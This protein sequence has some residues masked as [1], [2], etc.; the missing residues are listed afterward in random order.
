VLLSSIG[1]PSPSYTSALISSIIV[2]RRFIRQNREIARVNSTQSLRIRNLEAEISRL[3]AENIAIREQAINSAQEVERLRSSQR[4]FRDVSR[5]KEQLGAKLSEAGA[6]VTELGALPEKAKRRSSQHQRRR[7]GLVEPV[8]SPDQKDWKNRQTIGGG[9][10]GERQSQDGRLPV[11]VEGKHYPRKTLESLEISRLLDDDAA[12]SESP[13]LGP[14]PVAHFEVAEPIDFAPAPTPASSVAQ[15]L[16]RYQD[17]EIDVKAL[18]GNFERRRRRRASALLEDMPTLS[19][20]TT[21]ASNATEQRM[22]LKSGAKRKLDV[23][24]DACTTEFAPSELNDF[25]FQRKAVASETPQARPKGSRFIKSVTASIA[26]NAATKDCSTK[27]EPAA[28]KVLAPRSTN[29]P[30]KSKRTGLKEKMVPTK[31]EMGS[32]A[33]AQEQV[34]HKRTKATGADSTTHIHPP[35]VDHVVIPQEHASTKLPP[36]TPAGLDLFSPVSTE[37][38]AKTG[39]QTE[40]ALTASVEDVLGGVDGRTSRRARGAVSYTEPSLRAKM[41]RPTKG[42]VPAVG[43][44]TNGFKAQQIETN[45]RA[46]IQD[47]QFSQD[48]S[49]VKMRT[50]TI[51][52]EKPTDESFA[53]KGVP[54]AKDEPTSPLIN[55]VGKS[56]SREAPSGEGQEA[57]NSPDV[58]ADAQQ[59]EGAFESLSIFDGPVSSPHDSPNTATVQSRNPSRRHSSNPARLQRVGQE[60]QKPFVSSDRPQSKNSAAGTDD[61]PP[62]PS[63]AAS[64]RRENVGRNEK[65]DLRRAASVTTLKSSAGTNSGQGSGVTTGEVGAG[66]TERA[67]ARRRSMI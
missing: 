7:S 11:I 54:E 37:P 13:E 27:L 3:L 51:T 9:V 49:A 41:R 45:E 21:D 64:I 39:Q 60:F 52:R 56:A 67:A 65:M 25:A 63:S 23:R 10:I 43:D 17:H 57:E 4:I 19:C 55:K 2:K 36:K 38:S 15:T 8:K 34:D 5:L 1:L 61:R 42:L 24:E 6:L 28:R 20:S 58:N 44:Q 66:R 26:S 16:H 50:M 33:N 32:R 53:W 46:G 22:S 59:L 31:D 47:R 12:V 40:V 14:P 35:E 18:P 29:S 48:V 30:S 62:R